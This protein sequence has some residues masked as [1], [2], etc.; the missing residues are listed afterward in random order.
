[1][2]RIIAVCVYLCFQSTEWSKKAVPRFL[3]CGN[4]RKC[5]PILTIFLLLQQEMYDA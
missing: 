4:F 2:G 5:T 3:F 1:M